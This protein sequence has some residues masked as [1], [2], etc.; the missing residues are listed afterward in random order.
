MNSRVALSLVL[1]T[2]GC[3]TSGCNEPDAYQCTFIKR[4]PLETST[5]FCVNLK[6]KA[7][8]E[9]PVQEMGTWLTTSPDDYEKIRDWYK[10][11]CPK[12][13]E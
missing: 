13:N 11:Q 12:S 4:E 7:E 1:L 6:T 5:A 8:K 3:A 10:A 9:V 2:I